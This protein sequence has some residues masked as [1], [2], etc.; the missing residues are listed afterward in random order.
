M[1]QEVPSLV[2]EM[3]SEAL[4]EVAEEVAGLMASA[5]PF[6]AHKQQVQ[7]AVCGELQA[8]VS[9]IYSPPRVTKAARMLPHLGISAGFALDLT[10]NDEDGKP[11]DFDDAQQRNKAVSAAAQQSNTEAPL[12]R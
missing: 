5:A 10:V 3:P 11:W 1:S 12:S 9:E 7:S 4:R 6:G 8:V 2:R